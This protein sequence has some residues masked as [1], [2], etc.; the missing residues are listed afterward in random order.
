MVVIAAKVIGQGAAE[1]LDSEK[2]VVFPNLP[3]LT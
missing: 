3:G 2:A 1:R